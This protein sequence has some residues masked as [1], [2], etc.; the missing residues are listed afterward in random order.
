M[1]E[2]VIK[3][4]YTN[5]VRQEWNRLTKDAYHR[6]EFE[7]SLHTLE[8]FL[9]PQGLVLDA[10]GGPGRYTLELAKRGYTVSLMDLTP[11]N[12][13]FARKQIKRAG[14][15]KQVR[16]LLEGSIADLSMFEDESFDAVICLGGP[17]SHILDKHERGRAIAE[18]MR[19]AKPGAPIFVSVMS[20]LSVLVVVLEQSPY[21]LELPHFKQ[22]LETGEYFGGYGFTACHFFLPEELREAFDL[23]NLVF[24]EMVGLEGLASHH[25][26]ELNRVAK[27]EKRWAGWLDAHFRTCTH[28]AVVGTSEHMMIVCRK[29]AN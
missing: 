8:K 22:M 3:E 11:P 21:E 23:E 5:Q 25:R 24:E 20:R 18:L 7:T 15:Q 27:D 4:Y 26:T 10:G 1:T 2:T 9:P 28:P 12:L 13:D 6:L 19:V 16:T 29:K 14:M 17:L